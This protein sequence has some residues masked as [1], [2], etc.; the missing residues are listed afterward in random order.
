MTPT[1]FSGKGQ[2][3]PTQQRLHELE[4]ENRRLRMERKSHG[5]LCQGTRMRDQL[6]K[7]QQKAGPMTLMCMVLRVS[8]S[9][10]YDWT[11]RGLSERDG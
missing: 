9:G 4:S 10:H 7:N 6:I 8:R 2:R 11:G 3:A 1:F 5:L